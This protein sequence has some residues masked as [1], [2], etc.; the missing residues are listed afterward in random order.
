MKWI[1]DRVH[2]LLGICFWDQLS[3]QPLCYVL[4]S[5]SMYLLGQQTGIGFNSDVVESSDYSKES[6]FSEVV[7][8]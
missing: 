3:Q 8:P 2:S 4:S 1:Q 6:I 5:Q 7:T